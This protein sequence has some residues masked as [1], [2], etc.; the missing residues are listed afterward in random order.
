MMRV[1]SF[2]RTALVALAL[3]LGLGA[4]RSRE[5]GPLDPGDPVPPPADVT[6]GLAVFTEVCA[7]CHSSRDGFDLAFFGFPDST[8]V[9]RAVFHVDSGAARDIAAHVRTLGAAGAARGARIFQP[10][11]AVLTSDV[12]FAVRLFGAD[13][14]P[15]DMTTERLLA[16]DPLEI[17]VAVPFPRWSGEADNLD[18]MPD[19]PLPEA[20]LDA[21]GG[22]PRRALE[23]YYGSPTLEN[24]VAAVTALRGADRDPLD[25][26]APCARI[27]GEGPVAD[28]TG[29]FEVRRWTSTLAA[30]HML[31]GG[32]TGR[33]HPSLH[34][35]WWD[36]GNAA[37]LGTAG[38]IV[39][40][41][42]ANWASWMLL[43]WVFEPGR[44]ASV[45][46]GNGLLQSGLPRHAAFVALRSQ[47]ARP[48]GGEA[49]FADA[50][51]AARLAPPH[52]TFDATRFAYGHL[53][54]RLATGDRPAGAELLAE[55][56]SHAQQAY[57]AAALK[58]TA[59]Q[60]AELARL[61]DQILAAL[62]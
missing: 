28:G 34:D 21:R 23:R 55:A 50:A 44:H 29:C 10:G 52:W 18:W 5:G 41:R 3:L 53:L 39:D 20:I 17:A 13:A 2:P 4:C 14:W 1:D 37:R 46:T 9:R 16:L 25:P 61:R 32:V 58:V 8:I 45:Y 57:A 6:A 60:R 43:G 47:V 31:R 36:A 11:G 59:V 12:D 33:L 15:A 27:G 24:L 62:S 54:E 19:R 49:P 22:I 42:V 35:A 38:E 7:A 30:Q 40:H 51:Q 48:R 56:R 26:A